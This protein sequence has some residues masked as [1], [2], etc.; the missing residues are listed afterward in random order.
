MA[1]SKI[2][3]S[4]SSAQ[5]NELV[6]QKNWSMFTQPTLIN[7]THYSGGCFYGKFGAFVCVIISVQFDSAPTHQ[8]LWT[9]PS[10]YVPIGNVELSAS[11]GGSYNAKAQAI[12]NSSGTVHVTSVDRWVAAYGIYFCGA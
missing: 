6:L 12:V 8:L 1:E 9:M 4:L 7:G 10:G 3:Q 2:K 11:G 5:M